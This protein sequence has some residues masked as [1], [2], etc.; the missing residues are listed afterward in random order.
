MSSAV[1][2]QL[3]TFNFQLSSSDYAASRAHLEVRGLDAHANRAVLA[4]GWCRRRV[5]NQVLMIQLLGDPLGRRAKLAVAGDDLGV[6]AALIRQ[7]VERV[8]VDARRRQAGWSVDGNGVEEHVAADELLLQ[9]RNG[10]VARRV[11]TVG[12]DEQCGA[13]MRP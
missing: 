11:R 3:C 2:Y 13:R 12:D 1:R 4:V 7:I 6:A 8:G 5:A 10:D 9:G